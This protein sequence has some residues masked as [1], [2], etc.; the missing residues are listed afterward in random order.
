MYLLQQ[1]NGTTY[2]LFITVHYYPLL[3]ALLNSHPGPNVIKISVAQ[4][5]NAGF[6]ASDW[7]TSRMTSFNQSECRTWI[8]TANLWCLEATALPTT[9][10]HHCPFVNFRYC[11]L[12][13]LE[14]I[15]NW[16]I[17]CTWRATWE[18]SLLVIMWLELTLLRPRLEYKPNGGKNSIIG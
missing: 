16:L 5:R 10:P 3:F 12:L 9:L 13:K 1:K 4:V 8:W 2:C 17:N 6:N 14:S 15:Y 7:M 18:I 11:T